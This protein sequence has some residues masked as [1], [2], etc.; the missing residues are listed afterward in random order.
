MRGQEEEE[1]VGRLPG[2]IGTSALSRR[3]PKTEIHRGWAGVEV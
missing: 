3:L 1:Q 2:G